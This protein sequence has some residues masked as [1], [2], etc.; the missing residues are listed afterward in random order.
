[1]YKLYDFT[2][3]F[4]KREKETNVFILSF[5]LGKLDNFMNCKISNELITK[6]IDF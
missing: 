5:L 1:M 6:A 4:A 3:A 2:V